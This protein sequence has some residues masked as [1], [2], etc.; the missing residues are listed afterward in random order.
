MIVNFP[1]TTLNQSVASI[2][3]TYTYDFL[4]LLAAQIAM[5][6]C[7]LK[8]D[9]APMPINNNDEIKDIHI[10]LH[11]FISVYIFQINHMC[12]INSI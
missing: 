6:K 7:L 8:T 10:C 2:E 3:S 4:M 11:I 5:L 12:I 9:V 1:V